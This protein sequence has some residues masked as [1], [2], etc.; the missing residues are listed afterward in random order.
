[1]NKTVWISYDLG[2]KGDYPGLYRWI[3][4]TIKFG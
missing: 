3:E 2:I 1:M 4:K